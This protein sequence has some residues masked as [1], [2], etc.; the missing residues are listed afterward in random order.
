MIV[1]GAPHCVW[2]KNIPPSVA[3]SQP[4]EFHEWPFRHNV[5]DWD[6]LSEPYSLTSLR[7]QLPIRYAFA[8]YML[9]VCS[10]CIFKFGLLVLEHCRCL[11]TSASQRS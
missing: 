11:S 8:K 3:R 1:D 10:Q 2:E 9:L 4:K 6:G 7:D 5:R